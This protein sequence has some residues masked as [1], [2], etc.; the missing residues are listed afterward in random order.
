MRHIKTD[1]GNP[2]DCETLVGRTVEKY[3]RLDLACNNA[4]IG[5]ESNLTAEC[6]IEAWQK[7]PS[8]YPVFF[9][10]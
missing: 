5:G 4:V 8:I 2:A 9:S 6:S 1:V 10:A 7:V 3:G